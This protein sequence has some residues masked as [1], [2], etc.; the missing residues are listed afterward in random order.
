MKDIIY[1]F[2]KVIYM[3]TG[4]G[5]KL[6]KLNLNYYKSKGVKFG[7]NMRAFSSLLSSEPYLIEFGN[8][9][10]V[11]GKVSFITHDNSVIKFIENKTDVFG[12][13]KVGNNCFIGYGTIVLPGIELGDNTIVAAGSVV[14]KSFKEGNLVIGGNPAKVICSV[15]EYTDKIKDKALNTKGMS[16]TDKK[17][18]LIENK[19]KFICK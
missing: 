6:M 11:S 15:D 5:E 7:K 17:N 3:L 9:V 4:E 10:T 12:R 14:T 1:R 16:Y 2:R 8:N 18:Y 19:N 13:I